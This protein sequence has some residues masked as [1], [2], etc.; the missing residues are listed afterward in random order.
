MQRSD[1]IMSEQSTKLNIGRM[2]E[3]S[4]KVLTFLK[5]FDDCELLIEHFPIIHFMIMDNVLTRIRNNYKL[6][7]L[8]FRKIVYSDIKDVFFWRKWIGEFLKKKKELYR[9]YVGSKAA[10]KISYVRFLYDGNYLLLRIRNRM[11]NRYWAMLNQMDF[12]QQEWKVQIKN[13][14]KNNKCI[15][16]IGSEE[17]GNLGDNEIAEAIMK[18]SRYY[19][20]DYHLLE[21]TCKDFQKAKSYLHKYIKNEDVI[22]LTGGGNFGNTYPLSD[23]IREYIITGWQNNLKIVFPQTIDFSHNDEGNAW[24]E[25]AQRVYTKEHNVIVFTREK[26][27]F[28]IAKKYFQCSSYLVPDIVLFCNE[29]QYVKRE[30]SVLFCFRD[31]KEKYISETVKESIKKAVIKSDYEIKQTDLQLPYDIKKS[32]RKEEIMKKMDDMRK[33]SLVITD[34]LHGMIF[35]VITGTPCI[36]FSNY[37]H[38]IKGTY[39]W[40]SYL[41]YVKYVENAEEAIEWI[42]KLI[43]MQDCKYDNTPLLPYYDQ[44]AQVVKE[45]GKN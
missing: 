39:E 37:N 7:P 22:F 21:V 2:N 44:L 41:P 27:S 40:I 5:Q 19:F 45:N 38:K 33:S 34:R 14:S 28:Y 24:L 3:L 23:N 17:Y 29:H 36:V 11:I 6:S 9:I 18:F 31:D 16:Y 30:E 43:K 26:H 25:K 8:E 32:Q 1:S 4:K 20:P 35:A 42:P 10:V 12:V 13:F 15:Y